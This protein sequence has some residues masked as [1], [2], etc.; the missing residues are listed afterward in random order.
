[1]PGL[2]ESNSERYGLFGVRC[3]WSGWLLCSAPI[4]VAATV[5]AVEFDRAQ[6]PW[7][8]RLRT[9]FGLEAAAQADVPESG[10]GP[11]PQRAAEIPAQG[12]IPRG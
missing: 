6:E 7:A 10:A 8:R 3:R 9:R 11:P 5:I 1:M 2:M 4:V 12:F